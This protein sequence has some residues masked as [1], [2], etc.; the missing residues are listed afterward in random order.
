VAALLLFA[1]CACGRQAAA[2]AAP[3]PQPAQALPAGLAAF[4]FTPPL[5]TVHPPAMHRVSGAPVPIDSGNVVSSDPGGLSGPGPGGTFAIIPSEGDDLAWAVFQVALGADDRPVDVNLATSEAQGGSGALDPEY[6]LGLYSFSA[7]RWEWRY[8]DPQHPG[9]WTTAGVQSLNLNSPAVRDRYQNLTQDTFIV[10]LVLGNELK[11]TSAASTLGITVDSGELLSLDKDDSAYLLT[12]P[13]PAQLAQVTPDFANGEIELDLTP[14][15]DG[16]DRFYIERR[17]PGGNWTEIGYV[18]G[19]V[20][21]YADPVDNY[22]PVADAPPLRQPCEY[23]LAAANL[24]GADVLRAARSN[25]KRGQLGGWTPVVIDDSQAEQD[26]DLA[27]IGGNPAVSYVGPGGHLVYQR[28][29][30][31]DG[32]RSG[33]WHAPVEVDTISAGTGFMNDIEEINGNPAIAYVDRVTRK[34]RYARSATALGSQAADWTALDVSGT[35]DLGFFEPSLALVAGR[36]AIA[37]SNDDP[38]AQD[39]IYA[40]SAVSANGTQA[41]DWANKVLVSSAGNVGS[42]PSLCVVDNRPAIAY[43]DGDNASLLYAIS[44]DSNGTNWLADYSLGANGFAPNLLLVDGQPAIALIDTVNLTAHFLR[45]TSVDGLLEDTWTERRSFAPEVS[46]E[47]SLALVG[48]LPALA[49]VG[50]DN[51]SV[52]FGQSASADGSGAWTLD[53]TGLKTYT[54]ITLR[55]AGG[56]P[57]LV[58]A[59]FANSYRPTYCTYY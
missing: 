59:D 38:A 37:Y 5:A 28:A 42:D 44:S 57:V 9:P 20:G 22:D 49:V 32:A 51:R 35:S 14:P 1:L 52:Y 3:A 47:C 31:P 45:S 25:E 29:F 54:S 17:L 55:A 39:L 12:A 50:D 53:D 13:L 8:P 36:P 21:G 19:G 41:G 56:R 24:D 27:I 48:G 18:D 43:L 10:V 26:F 40:R 6:W 30:T 2:P 15:A 34:L 46:A 16:C 23:R 7:A 4:R 58:Y 33:D 11:Q